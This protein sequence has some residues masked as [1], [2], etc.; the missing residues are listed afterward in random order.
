MPRFCL[1]ADEREHLNVALRPLAT[2]KKRLRRM[3]SDRAWHGDVLR[4]TEQRYEAG[5]EHAVDWAA[6]KRDLRARRRLTLEL[7]LLDGERSGVSERAVE[8][9]AREARQRLPG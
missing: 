9:V 2:T 5:Q 6:A 1:F 4:E 7:A 8:D 3:G